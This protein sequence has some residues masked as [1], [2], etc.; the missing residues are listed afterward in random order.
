MTNKMY[1]A[2]KQE[3]EDNGELRLELC[4]EINSL[5]G[6]MDFVEVYDLEELAS[7]TNAY[8]L[9]RTIIY[10]DVKD[11]VSPVRYNGY[12]NLESV[13]NYELEEES[14]GY[15]DEI[16]Q[17]IL[18]EKICNFE[19]GEM[20]ED[21]DNFEEL[22]VQLSENF[23]NFYFDDYSS[24]VQ[25]DWNYVQE[26]NFNED[27]VEKYA[28]ELVEYFEGEI[29]SKYLDYMKESSREYAIQDIA[30]FILERKED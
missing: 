5:D 23:I 12:A 20:L 1:K 29:S 16:M 2:I 7:F 21:E 24:E 4:K 27:K 8:E 25:I 15:I 18:D 11:I 14:E 13:T 17:Y 26:I 3:L 10:G 9:A 19:I 28:N 6:N 22:K 30:N